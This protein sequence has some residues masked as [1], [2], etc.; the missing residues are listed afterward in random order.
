MKRYK[1]DYQ[2]LMPFDDES[3]SFTNG[4]ECGQMFNTLESGKDIDKKITHTVN[5]NQLR[6][7]CELFNYEF[8]FEALN[9][10]W[11]YF[12]AKLNILDKI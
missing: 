9:E 3:E 12:T 10:E 5:R 8:S 2:S 4:F 6:K 11:D 1:D 7:M